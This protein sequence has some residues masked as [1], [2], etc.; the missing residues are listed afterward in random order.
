MDHIH[1]R[2]VYRILVHIQHRPTFQDI[3]IKVL[4][5][6]LSLQAFHSLISLRLV[7]ALVHRVHLPSP[8]TCATYIVYLKWV[9]SFSTIFKSK[10]ML[11]W[12]GTF[13]KHLLF[14]L[15]KTLLFEHLDYPLK[16]RLIM[17]VAT[18]TKWGTCYG[19]VSSGTSNAFHCHDNI[20][21][22]IIIIQCKLTFPGSRPTSSVGAAQFCSSL[23]AQ[24]LILSAMQGWSLFWQAAIRLI[25]KQAGNWPQWN[26]QMIRLFTK[27]TLTLEFQ[28]LTIHDNVTCHYKRHLS[29]WFESIILMPID[30]WFICNCMCA[31]S[32]PSLV[33]LSY[34]SM[35]VALYAFDPGINPLIWR[36]TCVWLPVVLRSVR[37]QHC[38]AQAAY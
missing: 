2:N 26:I 34:T 36:H 31:P 8:S 38:R 13:L 20:L 19:R 1:P 15:W 18:D 3:S 11:P 4:T 12:F 33:W 28:A 6:C 22:S 21:L 5:I 30:V 16:P 32:M 17:I 29:L 10:Q 23:L 35:Y 24:T 14:Y 7:I 9:N 27:R 25:S 37:A